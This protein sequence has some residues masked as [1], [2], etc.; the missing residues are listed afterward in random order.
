MAKY[1]DAHCHLNSDAL[2]AGGDVTHWIGNA[3]NES[4]WAALLTRAATDARIVP[5]IGVHPW[6]MD[7]VTDGWDTRLHD[8]LLANPD[9]MIGECG[10]DRS[11]PNWDTQVDVFARQLELS[12]ELKR[13]VHIHCVRAWDEVLHLVRNVRLTRVVFHAFYGT[14]AVIRAMPDAYFSYSYRELQ[15]NTAR[16]TDCITATRVDRLLVETDGAPNASAQKLPEIITA[17]AKIK[18]VDNNELAQIIYNNTKQV[19]ENG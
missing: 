7:T 5:C 12:R 16:I 14:P 11:R 10:L 17:I 1:I 2:P 15:R 3:T 6:F 8:A 19:I 9:T 4:D 13:T 18:S